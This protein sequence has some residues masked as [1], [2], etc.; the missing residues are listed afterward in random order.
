MSSE[1]KRNKTSNEKATEALVS[2][3]S[4]PVRSDS[5]KKKSS[6]R[7]KSKSS[8]ADSR[9]SNSRRE[10]SEEDDEEQDF[11]NGGDNESPKSFKDRMMNLNLGA[12]YRII[13]KWVKEANKDRVTYR[14]LKACQLD[15]ERAQQL[16]KSATR[17]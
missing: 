5:N 2:N 11:S 15:P 3:V 1:R 16:I 12:P 9:R 17:Q 10:A 8:S 6:S 4:T 7:G 13:Q 14:Q